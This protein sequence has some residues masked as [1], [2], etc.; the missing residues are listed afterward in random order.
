MGLFT[1]QISKVELA[2]V[3]N[4][5]KQVND[6]TKLVNTT[7]KPDVFFGRLNFLFDLFLELKKYEKYKIFK[8]KTPTQ[9]YNYL[10]NN[11]EHQVNLFI[12]RTYE[13]QQEKMSKL[14]TE[15]SKANSFE[16][17]AENMR[18]SFKS[19]NNFWQGSSISSHYNGKLY[20][21]NNI[22]YLEKVLEKGNKSL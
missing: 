6:S 16:K 17:Y 2:E 14:K 11:L 15:K 3:K 18:A 21:Q 9:D 20:T 1:P 19:A 4:M 12:D 7:V 10:L 13:K 22:L 8:G 5:L